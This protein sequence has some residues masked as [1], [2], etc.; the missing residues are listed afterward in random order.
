MEIRNPAS[1]TSPPS[2]FQR[3]ERPEE[4][5]RQFE[6]VF[7]RQF[8][9][10]MTDGLF[11]A[12]LTGEDGPNWMESQSDLQ[13]S[14]LADVL[15]RHLVERGHFGIADHVLRQ[16]GRVTPPDETTPAGGSTPPDAATSTNPEP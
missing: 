15:T 14:T 13:R 16:W 6:E 3:A 9:Q 12:R 7:V 2:S 11:K 5:A 10:T 8:V 4:A 1:V